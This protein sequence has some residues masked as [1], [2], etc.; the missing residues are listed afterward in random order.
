MKRV[1]AGLL[2]I[3]LIFSGISANALEL[4]T[5]GTME[6]NENVDDVNVSEDAIIS[7]RT[8]IDDNSALGEEQNNIDDECDSN[9]I[10]NE[11]S[12]TNESMI[13]T[14]DTKTVDHTHIWASKYDTT[15]HWEYCTICGEKRNVTTHTYTDH[16]YGGNSC[17][18]QCYS[19][20]TCECGYSYTYRKPHGDIQTIWQ[21]TNAPRAIH[22]K[23]CTVCWNW[24]YSGKCRNS[25]GNLSCKNPGTCIDCG[26][27]VTSN[28]HYISG[29]TGKCIN[30]GKQIFTK[31][32]VNVSYSD[33]YSKAYVAFTI[34][35]SANNITLTNSISTG[36]VS[37]YNWSSVTWNAITNSDRS[38]TYTMTYTFNPTLQRKATINVGDI[39]GWVKVDGRSAYVDTGIAP[40]T[41]W[42]D[43]VAPI[44]NE[45]IQK[46]QASA[47]GWATIKQLTISGTENLSDIV[48]ITISDKETGEKYVT[49]ASTNVIDN[50][51][52]YV[53]TPVIEGDASGRTYVVTVTD[54]IGN[55]S[56][57]EFIVE[58]T[59]GSA[60]ALSEDSTLKY[61]NWTN[62]AKNVDLNFYD[63]GSSNIQLSYNNQSSYAALAKSG[64]YYNWK[65]TY[66][67]EQTGTTDYILYVKDALGNATSYTLTVG[68]IDYTKPIVNSI[69]STPGDNKAAV[70]IKAADSAS[71]V[72][73][74]YLKDASGNI[75]NNTT[76]I[77][78]VNKIG[79]Y[80][81]YVMDVAGNIS[82]SKNV[83]VKINYTLTV[84]PNGGTWNNSTNNQPFSL[85]NGTEKTIS[86]PTKNG[87]TFK[88]WTLSGTGSSFKNSTFTMGTTN[89][90]LTANWVPTNYTITYN[91]DGGS[92]SNPS[93]YNIKTDTFTLSNPTKTGYTFA[94]WTGSNGSTK[95]TSV[96]IT[97]GSTGDKTYTANWVP[98]NYT[99]TYNLNGGSASNP[100]SYNIKTDTFTLSNPTKTGYT[101][102][103][104]T[105]SNGS[106]KQTSVSITKGSTGDKSYTANYSINQYDVTYIDVIDSTNGTQL[107]KTTKKVNYNSN[108]RGSD[109]GSS[110]SD[111][112]YYNGYYYSSDT[113]AIVTTNGA[114]V[115][116][117]FKL[118]TI[119]KTSNLT[120]NDNNNKN[121]F[122]PSKYTLKLMRNGAL[123]KQVE[124]ASSQTSYTFSNLTKYDSNGNA[125]KYT[126]EV[127]TNS[128]RYKMSID[129]NGNIIE[130]YQNSSFSVIIP[131]NI[132]LNGNTGKG[133][134]NIKVNGTFYYNDTLTVIPSN[135]FK[136]IDKSG[137]SNINA[138][139]TQDTTTF[140]KS[141][142]ASTK[143]TITLNKAKFAG[144]Y[145]GTFNFAIKFTMKN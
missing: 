92:A 5:N 64:E 26:L 141:N 41:I 117:I 62:T 79:S 86:N 87:Y 100:S 45:V 13:A 96:S 77:F 128:D 58:K 43:H 9:S 22:Y 129:G 103:G 12:A 55:A 136:M 112:A 132:S 74:Y 73:T 134:Y 69:S 115:Y 4:S 24:I 137:I 138:S 71:G 56:T 91:L 116:R 110:T 61:T 144:S 131:K 63:F 70:T 18:G 78:T 25:N 40:H 118:R 105:G 121:G 125:F 35:P 44:Q 120:W 14:Y 135:S 30:C 104:W 113:S 66:S 124:L 59:D 106:T 127:D 6:V 53:C 39:T 145:T 97:K 107:G 48:Y 126:F 114:T 95:Q 99:I 32:G 28:D 123:F 15:N 84:N 81:G 21:K 85:T 143:G 94:G 11:E 42:Q 130:N 10:E 88:G 111:N 142:L 57:K 140:T 122:R 76:G 54:R 65:K 72:K 109:I 133:S 7:E 47:N 3:T 139:V 50:K 82:D 119:D 108:V 101:F 90:S 51:F 38:V 31:S 37:E 36:Y 29:T 17:S 93:S 68:N 23:A 1:L 102:S 19:I 75:Q 46:D 80:T 27:V 16:W 98:I 89:A 60:P 49:N 52:S 20:R 67:A 2:S 83:D 33:D 8:I 34:T